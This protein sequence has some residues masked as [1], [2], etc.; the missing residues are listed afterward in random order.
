VFDTGDFLLTPSGPDNEVLTVTSLGG[1]GGLTIQDEGSTLTT[2][3]TSINFVG[4]G[5]TASGGPAVT[6]TIPG[7]GGGGSAPA[8]E[9]IYGLDGA[10]ATL[11]ITN[12]GT[13]ATPAGIF[14]DIFLGTLTGT[15]DGAIATVTVNG[16][17]VI[18]SV[19]LTA[20]GYGYQIGD[21]L[22]DLGS[23]GGNGDS[24]LTVA[25]VQ[26]GTASAPSL[27]YDPLTGMTSVNYDIVQGQQLVSNTQFGQILTLSGLV[28]GTGYVD[29][30]YSPIELTGGSG[31]NARVDITVSG[32]AVTAVTLSLGFNNYGYTVGDVLTL[33]NPFALGHTPTGGSGFSINVATINAVGYNDIRSVSINGISGR[34]N[35]SAQLGGGGIEIGG[36]NADF[37]PGVYAGGIDIFT[38]EVFAPNISVTA[39]YVWSSGPAADQASDAG[40][41]SG[42]TNFVT[43]NIEAFNTFVGGSGYT[44]GTQST[45]FTGGSG[46]FAGATF[47]IAGGT[48][49]SLASVFGGYGYQVGDVLSFTPVIGGGAGFSVTVAAVNTPPDGYTGNIYISGGG[50]FGPGIPEST[51]ADLA[52]RTFGDVIIQ[53]SSS[54]SPTLTDA[55]RVL[56]QTGVNGNVVNRIVADAVGNVTVGTPNLAPAST[57]GFVYIPKLATAG[58]PSAAPTTYPGMSPM[59][60][61]DTAGVLTLWVYQFTGTPGWKSVTLT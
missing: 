1:G 10:I 25:T 11:T 23:L 22:S 18:T 12:G 59:L 50:M 42:S 34:S 3:A 36:G 2:G 29:G 13:G 28:G 60:I 4:A 20:F 43:G 45:N 33:M 53:G 47:T 52:S 54:D 58:P 30:S 38:G 27:M 32:G 40:I 9:I 31:Y 57:D 56:V 16:G 26:T 55:G 51:A 48:V 46:Q 49:V 5:V 41:S 24:I 7:G 44:N 19:V 39:G 17:G 21:T 14:P 6:V 8:N 15:G 37:V 35:T 61:E